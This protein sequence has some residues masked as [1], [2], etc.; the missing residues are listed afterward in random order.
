MTARELSDYVN[1]R[2]DEFSTPNITDLR[3]SSYLNKAYDV[4]L[5]NNLPKYQD[6]EWVR[7]AMVPLQRLLPIAGS[8]QIYQSAIADS[9]WMTGSMGVFTNPCGGKVERR[10]IR[11]F[12]DD[13][14]NTVLSDSFAHPTNIYPRYELRNNGTSNIID[15]FSDTVANSFEMEYI[16]IPTKIDL[17]T[18][19]NA[20]LELTEFY[21]KKV[22]DIAVFQIMGVNE[23]PRF[24]TQ[25]AVMSAERLS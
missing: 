9:R 12:K 25:T 13:T 19:P 21:M 4:F 7:Q 15:I 10:V 14:K 2:L 24:N 17:V 5:D 23:D 8:A 3:M 16:K 11:P 6:D 18:S 22:G 20:T 1:Q